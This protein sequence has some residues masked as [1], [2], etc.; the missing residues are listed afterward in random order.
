MGL[1]PR[2]R[3]GTYVL[4]PLPEYYSPVPTV[5]LS[6]VVVYEMIGPICT[7]FAILQAGESRIGRKGGESI[8]A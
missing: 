2:V 7:K 3:L 5:V 1:V 4:D 8:R 6:A